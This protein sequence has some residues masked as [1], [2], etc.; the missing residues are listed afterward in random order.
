MHTWETA[1]G[2]RP[3]VPRRD[4]WPVRGGTPGEELTVRPPTTRYCRPGG[5]GPPATPP[6]RLGNATMPPPPHCCNAGRGWCQGRGHPAQMP[7]GSW[8]WR[9]IRSILPAAGG[10]LG[11]CRAAQPAARCCGAPFLRPAAPFFSAPRAARGD[12][13]VFIINPPIRCGYPART[14]GHRH[15]TDRIGTHAGAASSAGVGERVAAVLCLIVRG[16][17]CDPVPISRRC[18]LLRCYWRSSRLWR[19]RRDCRGRVWGVADVAPRCIRVGSTAARSP[20]RLVC[21]PNDFAP[22]LLS[23]RLCHDGSHGGYSTDSW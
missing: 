22:L 19:P 3:M 8:P 13:H 2:G 15:C 14:R 7:L 9:A 23:L 17:S 16:V 12:A 18:R 20:S 4:G 5:H 1:G 11:V 21:E 10:S 6:Q